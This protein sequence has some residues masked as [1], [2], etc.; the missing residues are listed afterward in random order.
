MDDGRVGAALRAVRTR[1]GWRQIDV[2]GRAG[3]SRPMVS[4]IERGHLDAAS[5][6]VIRRVAAT[7]DVRLHVVAH[8]RGGD[9]GRVLNARHSALHESVATFILTL[10]GWEFV[11]EVS[12]SI[13]GERGVIDIL[14]WHAA[15]RTLLIIELKTAIVDVQELVGSMDRRRRLAG[16]IARQRG[17]DPASVG[18]WVIVSGTKSNQRRIAAHRTM[19]RAAFPQDGRVLRGWLHRPSGAIRCLSMWTDVSAGSTRPARRAALGREIARVGGH[20]ES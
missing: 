6:R 14:A 20:R 15:T 2:A 16:P 11:P 17:W 9:L 18:C 8:W 10:P 1:R 7:L 19:L 4:L 5:L 13:Y 12:F 3:V